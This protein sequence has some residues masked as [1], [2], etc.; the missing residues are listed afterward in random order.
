MITTTCLIFSRA[1]DSAREGVVVLAAV[2]SGAGVDEGV[3]AGA[4]QAAA[5]HRM[6]TQAAGLCDL[7]A[8][9]LGTLAARRLNLNAPWFQTLARR[10]QVV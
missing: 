10:L 4:E 5:S 8:R 3:A 1:S 7:G 9:T 6:A 2:V